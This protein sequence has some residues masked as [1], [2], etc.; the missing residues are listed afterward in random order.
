MT[1]NR[2]SG[3]PRPIPTTSTSE[4]VKSPT[5][6]PAAQAAKPVETNRVSQ[7]AYVNKAA[8]HGSGCGCGARTCGTVEVPLPAGLADKVNAAI[9]ARAA[10]TGENIGAVIDV[11]FHVVNN[12]E[13]VENGNVTKEMIDAQIQVLNDAYKGTGYAFNLK[14]VTRTTNETWYTGGHG[15]SAERA[16]K[17]TLHRGDASDLNVYTTNP[18]G[19]LL[20]WA[21]FPF[22][23]QNAPKM[24]GVVL[25]ASSLP[26][27]SS[28]PFNEG[29]TG[30]HEVGHWM[31]LYHTFQQPGDEV[32]DTPYHPKPNFGKPPV[33]TDTSPQPGL[34]PIHNYMNYVDD[35]WMW[36]FTP[37]QDA[38]MDVMWKEFRAPADEPAPAK[39]PVSDAFAAADKNGN[40]ELNAA[41]LRNAFAGP[42]GSSYRGSLAGTAVRNA[43]DG[44]KNKSVSQ[45]ELRAGLNTL[46]SSAGNGSTITEQAADLFAKLDTSGDGQLTADELRA[47]IQ[48][49]LKASGDRLHSARSDALSK[50][51]VALFDADGNGALDAAEAAAIASDL[52]R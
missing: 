16:M 44:D 29:D 35:D 8:T 32:D 50:G 30:T 47:P 19:G 2:L 14:E 7:D 49:A 12:G 52:D 40:G 48:D 36:E 37:G 34:D 41:E 18:G 46:I 21:T 4:T 10:G 11:Y 3:A 28:A 26:G 15:S 38:R 13:G 42:A 23:Q 9:A 39:T 20:G 43:L 22:N 24:D 31:G 25:L 27:G 1:I 33:G 45:D 51:A 5:A 6:A 17:E